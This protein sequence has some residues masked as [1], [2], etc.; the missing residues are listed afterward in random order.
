MGIIFDPNQTQDKATKRDI[1]KIKKILLEKEV[2]I[3]YKASPDFIELLVADANPLVKQIPKPFK[4]ILITGQGIRIQ[5]RMM[6][7]WI[8]GSLDDKNAFVLANGEISLVQDK[9][10]KL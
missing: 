4:E 5:K 7:D 9:N 3:F 10:I 2:T 6:L 8:E 1:G